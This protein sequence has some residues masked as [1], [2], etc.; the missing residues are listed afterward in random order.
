MSRK[1]RLKILAPPPVEHEID[2]G[3]LVITMIDADGKT[4]HR[5]YQNFMY[6]ALFN[7][8]GAAKK[9]ALWHRDGNQPIDGRII[10]SHPDGIATNGLMLHTI[11]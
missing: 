8:F 1:Q 9:W 7:S 3:Y 11:Y 4:E 2:G 6:L 10:A 5:V